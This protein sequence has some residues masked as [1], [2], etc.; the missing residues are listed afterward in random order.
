MI[1]FYLH[2]VFEDMRDG[3]KMQVDEMS[4]VEEIGNSLAEHMRAGTV[5]IDWELSIDCSKLLMYKI[6]IEEKET[7]PEPEPKKKGWFS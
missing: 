3:V 5:Y 4:E 7:E 2:L 6:I 1:D